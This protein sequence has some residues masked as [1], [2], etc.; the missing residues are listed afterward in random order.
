MPVAYLSAFSDGC[1][2][3]Y[4][5]PPGL[6]FK[7]FTPLIGESSIQFA[8]GTDWENRRKYL[9]GVFKGDDLL[10]YFPYFVKIAQVMD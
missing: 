3:T 7:S 8:N 4:C 1:V 10:S 5:I 6:F 9:Y 2:C